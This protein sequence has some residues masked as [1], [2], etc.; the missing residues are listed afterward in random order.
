MLLGKRH[1]RCCG[2]ARGERINHDP[3]GLSFDEGD[4]GNIKS[5]QLVHAIHHLIEANVRVQL[6]MAPQAGVHGIGRCALQKIIGRKVAQDAAIGSQY[7]AGGPRDQ[8]T[9]GVFKVLA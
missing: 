8:S 1:R 7:L 5:T 3:A 4:V 6:R 2:L 9:L